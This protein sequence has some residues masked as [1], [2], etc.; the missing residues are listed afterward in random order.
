MVDPCIRGTKGL[1]MKRYADFDSQ[2]TKSNSGGF[3]PPDPNG[4]AGPSSIIAVVNVAIEK[5]SRDGN[6]VKRMKLADFF[7]PIHQ[8]EKIFDP[9]VRFDFFDNIFWVIMVENSCDN[10]A[11]PC[12]SNILIAKSTTSDPSLNPI[13]WVFKRIDA[14]IKEFHWLDYPGF[15]FDHEMIYITAN[16]LEAT[17]ILPPGY[18]RTP[19]D[20]SYL[21]VLRKSNLKTHAGPISLGQLQ[22][23]TPAVRHA[24]WSS[25]TY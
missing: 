25:G 11:P 7:K 1:V 10:K 5:Q 14:R 24:G 17:N 3:T 18:T 12:V 23:N 9:H 4:A 6:P 15:S 19:L 2:M 8:G 20:K 13:D 16:I 22:T 21:W